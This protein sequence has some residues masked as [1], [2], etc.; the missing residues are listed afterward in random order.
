MQ[1]I[2]ERA[3]KGT[4][5]PETL[6]RPTTATSGKS[7]LTSAISEDEEL[8]YADDEAGDEGGDDDIDDEALVLVAQEQE[9]KDAQQETAAQSGYVTTHSIVY[10]AC[11][12]VCG[13]KIREPYF[14]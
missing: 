1:D 13:N 3:K 6:S 12:I 14:C 10:R 11:N 2:F 5:T 9:V 4:L 8:D 7:K